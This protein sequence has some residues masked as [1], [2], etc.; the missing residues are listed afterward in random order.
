MLYVSWFYLHY[1]SKM[2]Q[3]IN[4]EWHS[5]HFRSKI[6]P[7]RLKGFPVVLTPYLDVISYLHPTTYSHHRPFTIPS[8]NHESFPTDPPVGL[9]LEGQS[10]FTCWFKAASQPGHIEGW[11]KGEWAPLP[12]SWGPPWPP[13][14][15][16]STCR[17]G[18]ALNQTCSH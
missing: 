1:H 4:M 2:W 10:L 11:A 5:R 3:E 16:P 18:E 6:S 7:N 17:S 14:A 9:N 13:R 8:P 15:S 12:L